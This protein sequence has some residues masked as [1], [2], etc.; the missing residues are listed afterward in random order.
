MSSRGAIPGR[1]WGWLFV[2][3]AGLVWLSIMILSTSMGILNT[4]ITHVGGQAVNLGFVTGDLNN[5]GQHLLMG[6]KRAPVQQTQGSWD[7]HWRRAALLAGIWISFLIGAVL[8]AALGSR[9]TMWALLLPVLW[10]QWMTI[11]F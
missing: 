1:V 4:S 5:L 7:T 2:V 8:G 11:T 10:W 9:F 3:V 6:I